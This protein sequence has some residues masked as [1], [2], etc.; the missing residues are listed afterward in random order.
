MLDGGRDVWW[1]AQ[2]WEG[3]IV[4]VIEEMSLKRV[5]VMVFFVELTVLRV[6]LKQN[7]EGQ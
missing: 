5:A 3:R 6:V 2:E 4:D 7:L 1:C